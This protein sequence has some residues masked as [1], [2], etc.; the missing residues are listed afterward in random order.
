MKRWSTSLNA[1]VLNHLIGQGKSLSKGTEGDHNILIQ[2]NCTCQDT[3]RNPFHTQDAEEIIC[4]SLN[5]GNF[6]MKLIQT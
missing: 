1:R 2:K 5:S 6:E 4:P 3:Q